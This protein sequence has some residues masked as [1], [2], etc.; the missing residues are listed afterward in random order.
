MARRGSFAGSLLHMAGFVCIYYG[1]TGSSWLLEA[2]GSSPDVLVPGFEPLENWA[3][4]ADDEAKLEW[5]ETAM[6]PPQARSGS[7]Y[8]AWVSALQ[9]SPQVSGDLVKPSFTRVGFKMKDLAAFEPE[10]VADVLQRTGSKV[11][12]LTRQ[13]RINRD[14]Q[15]RR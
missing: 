15:F 6:S 3:W 9:A 13:N 10:A 5:L 14:Q 7:E 11:I 4:K 2:L 1:N 8:E 12:L